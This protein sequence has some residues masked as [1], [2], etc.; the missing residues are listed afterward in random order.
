MSKSLIG[1][2]KTF[3]FCQP[4]WPFNSRVQAGSY[5]EVGGQVERCCDCTGPIEIQKYLSSKCY[6][7]REGHRAD[8]PSILRC[9]EPAHLETAL[10][11]KRNARKLKHLML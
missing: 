10:M 9:M 2:R 8:T 1:Q 3:Q 4:D 5:P 11:A 7:L 6:N